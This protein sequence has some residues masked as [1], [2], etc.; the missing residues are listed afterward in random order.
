M[1]LSGKAT[2]MGVLLAGRML[3]AGIPGPVPAL[4]SASAL[5]LDQRTGEALLAKHAEA[6]VP[7]A[8]L[9]KLMTAL[10][11]LEA[12]QDLNA[13]LRVE[14]EDVDQIRHSRSHLPV[15]T[16]LTRRELLEL[17][18]LA[19]ENRAAHAVGRN[20]PGGMAA[21]VAAM[22]AKARSMG[23]Q[24]SRFMDTS[25]LH[26]GNM[27]SAWDLAK[28]L[29]AASKVP[30]IRHATTLEELEVADGRWRRTFPNTNALVRGG[31]W[32]IGVSKT[33]FIDEAGP[34]LAMQAQVAGRPLLMVFLDAPGR[35]SRLGD[36][37][38]VRQWLG[39]STPRPT[40]PTLVKAKGRVAPAVARKALR[41]D[42]GVPVK[43]RGRKAAAKAV[44][45]KTAKGKKVV[46]A[47]ELKGKAARAQAS[48]AK[49]SKGKPS[50]AKPA[51][52]GTSTRRRH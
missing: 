19:S 17:A 3:L 2:W 27:A 9:T 31:S 6:V 39:E 12:R 34:C 15:G 36:A 38:R 25:G 21:C 1:E 52:S 42:R 13:R 16:T 14:P 4:K 11:V 28:I 29:D 30:E 10:V 7:I 45:A 51:K 20:Y 35:Y 8:S 50:K 33:G 37:T 41:E 24:Q 23:L 47:K 5:V 40:R 43:A 32:D 26:G 46:K 22:N 18:L 44:P 48:K 49:T